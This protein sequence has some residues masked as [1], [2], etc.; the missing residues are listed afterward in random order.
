MPRRA[1]FHDQG[2]A[3]SPPASNPG[4]RASLRR[5]ST[6]Y[7]VRSGWV[8]LGYSNGRS[9]N[10]R[11]V[12]ALLAAV[13]DPGDLD[14]VTLG[15]A[16]ELERE[17]GVLRDRRTPLRVQHRLA[18]VRD[19]DVLDEPCGNDLALRIPALPGLHLVTH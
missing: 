14:L 17:E 18:V 2:C 19:D 9:G 6:R 11:F 4:E 7:R 16:L 13:V 15:P 1:K 3:C 5:I 12:G 8:L 10:D